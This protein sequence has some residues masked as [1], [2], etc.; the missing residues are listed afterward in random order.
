VPT[1]LEL[2]PFQRAGIAFAQ[3][4]RKGTLFGDEMGLE[5]MTRERAGLAS[6]QLASD[7][8]AQCQ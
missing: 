4:N 6:V 7:G 8:D 5:S 1:G 2:Y 3:R